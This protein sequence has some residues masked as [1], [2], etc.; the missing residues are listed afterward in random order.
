MQEAAAYQ[1][2]IHLTV[3]SDQPGNIFGSGDAREQGA[4]VGYE[5]IPQKE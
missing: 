3:T 5:D 4:V 2:P 1:E